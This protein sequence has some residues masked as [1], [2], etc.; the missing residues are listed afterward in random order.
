MD[1]LDQRESWLGGNVLDGT[2]GRSELAETEGG[3]QLPGD[4]NQDGGVDIADAH[5]L[6]LLVFVGPLTI[7]LACDGATVTDGGNRLL[8]DLDGSGVV[9]L[10]DSVALLRYLFIGGASPPVLGIECTR[11]LGCPDDCLP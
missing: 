4:A 7:P 1:L 8:N 3:W 11:I 2:P 5:A 6:L 9:D 10:S